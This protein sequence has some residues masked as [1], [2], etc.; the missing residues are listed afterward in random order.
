VCT[1]AAHN[2]AQNNPDN[3]P[4]YPPDNH[5]CSDDVYLMEGAISVAMVIFQVNLGL[6][7]PLVFFLQLFSELDLWGQMAVWA[8]CQPRSNGVKEPEGALTTTRE[9]HRAHPLSHPVTNAENK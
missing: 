3:F 9:N 2:T 4:S 6:L 1:I 5:H 7:L 8:G